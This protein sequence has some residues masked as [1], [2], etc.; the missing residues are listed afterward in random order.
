MR[1]RRIS[2]MK[3]VNMPVKAGREGAEEGG[4][5]RGK[6]GWDVAQREPTQTRT[7]M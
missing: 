7:W 6:G 5:R 2:K 1:G 4:E 3:S